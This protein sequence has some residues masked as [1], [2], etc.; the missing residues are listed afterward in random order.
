MPQHRTH[1]E[2]R[3]ET[4][5]YAKPLIHLLPLAFDLDISLGTPMLRFSTTPDR[6]FVLLLGEAIDETVA[7]LE[8]ADDPAEQQDALRSLMPRSAQVF[9]VRGVTAQ[10]TRLQTALDQPTLYQPTDYHWLLLYEGLQAYCAEFNE[11]PHGP[12]AEDYG[13]N[14]LDFD[15]LVDLFFWDTD[16]LDAHIPTLSLEARQYLDIS[17][18]TVGLTA[19]LKPHPEE[20]ALTVCDAEMGKDFEDDRCVI[21][22]PGRKDYPYLSDEYLS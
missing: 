8:L 22:R 13:L 17:P 14:R 3:L 20:L 12:L 4:S 10:L 11:V 7:C 18:E 16:F 19:G 9:D 5:T 21:Y 6:I 15:A 1:S 2:T